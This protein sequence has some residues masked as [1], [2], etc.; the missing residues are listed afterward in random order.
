M[1]GGSCG[2]T[3]SFATALFVRP[4]SHMPLINKVVARPV[5]TDNVLRFFRSQIDVSDYLL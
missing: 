3:R 4:G 1:P 5:A 2:G